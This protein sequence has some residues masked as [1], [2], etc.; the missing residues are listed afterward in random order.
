MWD[1]FYQEFIRV[2]YAHTLE[3]SDL[4]CFDKYLKKYLTNASLILGI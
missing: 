2:E 3:T 1:I 4:R